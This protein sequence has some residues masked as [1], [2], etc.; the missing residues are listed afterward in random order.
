MAHIGKFIQEVKKNI[1]RVIDKQE[2]HYFNTIIVWDNP[3]FVEKIS[4]DES[5]IHDVIKIVQNPQFQHFVSSPYFNLVLE[6]N[7]YK[8]MIKPFMDKNESELEQ[9]QNILRCISVTD[10]NAMYKP[11]KL[12]CTI[13]G[14]LFHRP[15]R[16]YMA[17]FINAEEYVVHVYELDEHG[18]TKKM[19]FYYFVPLL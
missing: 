12:S 6:V 3:Y 18:K 16:K 14:R 9:L 17:N 1:D 4:D 13:D 10:G 19:L 8:I 11:R 15:N 5:I 2:Y 7:S